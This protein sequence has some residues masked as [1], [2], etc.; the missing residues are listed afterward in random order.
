MKKISSLY[1][2]LLCYNTTFSQLN[3]IVVDHILNNSSTKKSYA[4]FL[5]NNNKFSLVWSNELIDYFTKECRSKISAIKIIRRKLLVGD[6]FTL[7][8]N[9]KVTVGLLDSIKLDRLSDDANKGLHFFISKYFRANQLNPIYSD[10]VKE[11]SFCLWRRQT[12][13]FIGLDN[14]SL[15]SIEIRNNK[16]ITIPKVSNRAVKKPDDNEVKFYFPKYDY[17]LR[18]KNPDTSLLYLKFNSK[19]T[20]VQRLSPKLY[21]G[22]YE[23]AKFIIDTIRKLITVELYDEMKKFKIEEIYTYNTLQHQHEEINFY[24]LTSTTKT[25]KHKIII[26]VLLNK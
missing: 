10:L 13:L 24:K 20:D 15:P 5:E 14:G 25:I 4:I 9:G 6:T 1:I 23:Y 18:R 7:N 17:Y 2:F 12:Y 19:R 8:S 22:E 26:P 21:S 11:I 16:I 3:R